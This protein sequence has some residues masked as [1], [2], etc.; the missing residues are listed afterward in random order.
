MGGDGVPTRIT[1]LDGDNYMSWSMELEHIMRLRGCWSA[2]APLPAASAGEGDPRADAADAPDAAA[3]LTTQAGAHAE[4]QARS[5]MVL[6][7][8][9][10]HMTTFRR[11]PTARGAWL[12]LE[13]QF[14]SRGPAR[15][16]NLRRE[17]AIMKQGRHEAVMDYF[18]RASDVAWELEALGG[19]MDESQV[20]SAL[21]AGALPKYEVTVKLL[22]RV[23]DLDLDTAM[24]ELRGDEARF[25]SRK[26]GQSEDAGEAMGASGDRRPTRDDKRKR[27]IKCYNCGKMGHI[28]RDC[29]SKSGRHESDDESGTADYAMLAV[30]VDATDKGAEAP[31]ET[32]GGR[33]LSASD[34][35]NIEW[36]VDS[37]ASHHMTGRADILEEV[38]ACEPVHVMLADGKVRTARTSGKCVLPVAA[39]NKPVTVTLKTVLLVP[40]LTSSLFSVRE[41]VSNGYTVEFSNKD[42]VIKMAGKVKV[43]GTLTKRL[44]TFPMAVTGAASLAA[45]SGPTATTW[46]RRFG[47]LS[48][49]ALQQTA[50]VV[51]GMELDAAEVK[52]LQGGTCPPCITGK[53]TRAPFATGG[54]TTT[55]PLQ[56][57]FTDTMGK[58]PVPSTGGN[59]Y[60]TTVIDAHTKLKVAIPHKVRGM[61]KDIV[62]TTV[63]RWA[64]ETGHRPVDI[65][66]DGALDYEGTEWSVW[67]K[68]NGIHHQRT[69]PYTAEQN[70]VA[71][72]YNR[73]LMER[74]MAMMDDSGLEKQW[75]AEAALT[76]N[77]LS[78]RVP[79][80]GQAT[81]PFEAFYGKQPNVSHLRVFGCPAWAYTPKKIRGKMQPRAKRGIFLGYGINQ[82][83]YRVLIDGRVG[84]Y[85]D[86]RFDETH[87]AEAAQPGVGEIEPATEDGEEDASSDEDAGETPGQG[88]GLEAAPIDEAVAAARNLVRRA[89]EPEPADG[90]KGSGDDTADSDSSSDDEAVEEQEGRSPGLG[91]DGDGG[92][93]PYP[94]RH[95]ARVLRPRPTKTRRA[96][97]S[98]ATP[99]VLGGRGRSPGGDRGPPD[100]RVSRERQR[101]PL[102]AWAYA[103]MSGGSP[104]KMRLDQA[105]KQPDWPQF[106]AANKKEVDSL[107]DMGTFE[108]TNYKPWMAL[109]DLEMLSERKRG[110]NGE[111]TRHKGRCVARGDKQVYLRDYVDKWAPVLRH[112]T[113]RFMLA[114]AA[115]R[116]TTIL[117]LDVETAF[118]NGEIE[119]ELYVRQPRGYERG[120]KTKVC[121]LRKAIYGL[122]Q[123][124]R[125]W[126]LKLSGELKD[127]GFMPC[128]SDPCLFKGTCMGHDVYILVY[129]DDLLIISGSEEAAEQVQAKVTTAFKARVMGE[130][131]YFLGLHID[132]D[133]ATG[134]IHL[135]QRQYVATLLKRFGMQDANPVRLP[136]GAGTRLRKEGE[137]L[138]NDLKETYQELVGSLL[139][140]STC[141]R[142]DIAFV[143]GTLSRF[144]AAPTVEHLSAAKTVLRYL[145]GTANLSLHYGNTQPLQGYSDAD[146]ASDVDTRRS[147]TGY[148]FLVNGGAVSWMSK[149][150]P[151]VSTS[152]TEAEYIAAAMGAKEA[153][154]LRNLT[155]D[156]TDEERSV[157]LHCDSTS[158]LAMMENG[159][160]SPRTKHVD[161]AHHFIREKVAAKVLK[162][163]HVSTKEMVAD[164]LTKPLPVPAFETCRA[165][166][167]MATTTL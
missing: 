9:S 124:A 88:D 82:S 154:W 8:K 153:M 20:V 148:T 117:Q 92:A 85:R 162:V 83:G 27:P 94:S 105:R 37:G 41:A 84:T 48:A 49:G 114:M 101:T 91:G 112:S 142:P 136:I 45:V 120:D 25:A 30:V 133:S 164:I 55:A 116:K 72:R 43:R 151:S 126:Y 81:T 104:D 122:K 17:M 52:S 167:G 161:V 145:K 87:R 118:L 6:N 4:E 34:T 110:A 38:N 137:A 152:T 58:M 129:V 13:K 2:V 109:I 132:R 113:L 63:K 128:D 155:K 12:A 111:V 46:H 108:L 64:N 123:A 158:A 5:L 26:P 147:T 31:D 135:G 3:T 42:I 19:G 106:D 121:R 67:L 86:V 7:I 39:G 73:T 90:D 65:R 98:A 96:F 103:A 138:P 76:A 60:V 163:S 130:P 78:N 11:H 74:V 77:Y 36:I 1:K 15:L 66:S 51:K 97:L 107:W 59:I 159:V 75:W 50:K 70:G 102:Q 127:A 150:Q 35:H 144:M 100:T 10:R 93:L 62:M 14:R 119:E 131:T 32:D 53:M 69:N 61:A 71:E 157:S 22:L 57:I 16:N 28:A 56:L 54:P 21:L 125:A 166:L 134:S 156:V 79:Q 68:D 149:R 95:P 80:R 143:T 141:T 160:T 89:G 115:A 18:N 40:G 47:H 99:I 139:Y 165:G 29:R 44:Y 23:K 146:Y 140:L 24:E 33:A